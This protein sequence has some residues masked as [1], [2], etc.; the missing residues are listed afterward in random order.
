MKH[1]IML[2]TFGLAFAISGQAQVDLMDK[3]KNNGSSKK[4]VEAGMPPVDM[5]IVD[6]YR[7]ETVIDLEVTPV[8]NQG[9]SGTCWSYA[10]TSFVE[11]EMLRMGKKSVD[12]SE[13]FTVRQVYLDKA[14]KYVRL[15]GYLNFAQGGASPDVLY[16]IKKYGAVPQVAYEGLNYGTKENNHG[17]LEAV[18]KGILDEIIKNKNGALTTAWR[19]TVNAVLDAYLGKY[20]ETF[21]YEGKTYT[22]RTFADKVVGVNPDEYVQLTSFTNDPFYTKTMVQVPDNWT[23]A[24]AYNVPLDDMQAAVDNSLKEGYSISWATDVSEKG[25]SYK[26]GVAIVSATEYGDMTD[27][28]KKVMFDGPKP[29]MKITQELRQKAYDNYDTQDDHGMQITGV[30]KDQN[31]NEYYIVKNSWGDRGEGE[32]IGYIYTSKPFFRYKTISVLVHKDAVPK[33]LKKQLSM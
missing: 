11:S 9:K 10:T 20:P 7:F 30:A 23:W 25:F 17:E 1:K 33:S 28:E 22:P 27:E 12:L 2:L 31:G 13:M 29:E 19:P 26:K 18:L 3:V 14:E 6:E 8:K 16:V 5:Q 24:T 32:R 21:E 15:H 4:N